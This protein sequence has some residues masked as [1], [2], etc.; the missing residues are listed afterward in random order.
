M[1]RRLCKLL[2]STHPHQCIRQVTAGPLFRRH[3]TSRLID[4]LAAGTPSQVPLHWSC[5]DRQVVRGTEANCSC[6]MII[7]CV[8][9]GSGRVT[10][11]AARHDR[12]RLQSV[13]LVCRCSKW[14]AASTSGH[15]SVQIG[16]F[17]YTVQLVLLLDVSAIINSCTKLSSLRLAG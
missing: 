7:I 17:F 11:Q 9:G 6:E 16:F 8:L 15:D 2:L 10:V 5:N 4:W 14:L 3:S 1:T 12:C 13:H